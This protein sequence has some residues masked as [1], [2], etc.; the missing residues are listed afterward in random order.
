MFNE[1][2]KAVSLMQMDVSQIQTAI[3]HLQSDVAELKACNQS[4]LKG[5]PKSI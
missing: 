1:L 4:K 5:M 2:M 3:S